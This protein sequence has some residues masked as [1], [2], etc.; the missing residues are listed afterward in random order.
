[1]QEIDTIVYK[2]LRRRSF[3]MSHNRRGGG[4]AVAPGRMQYYQ[5]L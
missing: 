5:S 2:Q 3:N 1:M 4:T